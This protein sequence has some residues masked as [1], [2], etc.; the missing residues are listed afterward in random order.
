MKVLFGISSLGLGHAT[1]IKPLIKNY[2]RNG[3]KVHILSTGSI[4]NFLKEEF[5]KEITAYYSS[6]DI[7]LLERGKGA[8]FY[9][10][11]LIDVFKV[12]SRINK[13]HELVEEINK[14]EKFDLIISDVRYGCYSKGVKSLLV[15]HQ[16]S[17]VMP[18]FLGIFQKWA[19]YFNC[20]NFKHFD[21]VLI[22]DYANK[23]ENLAGELS[24]TNFLNKFN[25]E[26]IGILS[27]YEKKEVKQDIDY[28]FIISGYLHEHKKD[29]VNKLI[30]QSKLLEGKKVFVLGNT[31]EK[32]HKIDKKNN[33]EIYSYI[34]GKLRNDLMNRAKMVISRAGYST[35]MDL[36][37]LDKKAILIPTPG[38]T[39][40]EYLANYL[41]KKKFFI[42]HD[43][44]DNFDLG[45][46]L[47]E[48]NNIR[49]IK[50]KEKTN[51]AIKKINKIINS[52]KK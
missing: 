14:K 33:I 12:S 25:H 34:S 27:S 2:L 17:L 19:D 10:Y 30:E 51:E 4:F 47:K 8:M 48:M 18:K 52:I 22:P 40:Q 46:L 37:E 16:I 49:K 36:I 24:H 21:M 41:Y 15:N 3:W 26:Y 28:Y 7:P 38:Q 9:Y 29:F 42:T 44:Q 20:R 13:E 39:E 1:R 43:S 32:F 35:V 50:Q 45:K 31:N 23:K 6:E 5:G 11:L